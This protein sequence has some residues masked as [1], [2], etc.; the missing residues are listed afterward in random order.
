MHD[1][2]AYVLEGKEWHFNDLLWVAVVLYDAGASPEATS[3]FLCPCSNLP[4]FSLPPLGRAGQG[5]VVGDSEVL[6]L[7][8]HTYCSSCTCVLTRHNWFSILSLHVLMFSKP[9][10]FQRIIQLLRNRPSPRLQKAIC[11]FSHEGLCLSGNGDRHGYS[12]LMFASGKGP[13]LKAQFPWV[14]SCPDFICRFLVHP[15]PFCSKS[16]LHR[17]F[18]TFSDFPGPS[19]CEFYKL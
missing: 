5:C 2:M 10:A 13:S 18:G 16:H 15:V 1:D 7:T 14:M 4:C 6:F 17:A 19:P 12:V 8:W 3:E 9:R 11:F